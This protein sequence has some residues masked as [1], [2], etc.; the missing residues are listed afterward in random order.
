MARSAR[1]GY[2]D[3]LS[4]LTHMR[5]ADPLECRASVLADRPHRHPRGSGCVVRIWRDDSAAGHG[6]RYRGRLVGECPEP[7]LSWPTPGERPFRV[8]HWL[9][10][11][12]PTPLRPHPPQ[13]SSASGDGDALD[14]LR[15][16]AE[17]RCQSSSKPGLRLRPG[18]RRAIHGRFNSHHQARSERSQTIV[19]RRRSVAI[20]DGDAAQ[21]VGHRD[22]VESV[23]A[24]DGINTDLS[25]VDEHLAIRASR[26]PPTIR[27]TRELVDFW[28]A[29]LSDHNS[30]W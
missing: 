25:L 12:S 11:P 6:V 24:P 5:S 21:R 1:S 30:S 27:T 2:P 14:G 18:T 16:S 3:H 26:S 19:V 13:Q 29:T 28:T 10:A 4:E 17:F 22:F 20:G 8:Q 7:G 9:V 23:R 15:D